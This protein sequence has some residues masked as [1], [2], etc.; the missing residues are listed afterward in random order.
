MLISFQKIDIATETMELAS[1]TT[2]PI[3]SLSSTISSTEPRY[4]FYR[5]THSYN[6]SS[7]SPI[8][9][10]YTCP[11]GS[12][13]RERM[14]YAA[15]SRSAIQVA[16]AEAGLKVEKKIEASSPDEISEESIDADL[17]PK[18]EIKKA[19]ERPKRPGRK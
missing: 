2:T 5:Y 15:S 19:F 11:S 18:V 13:I 6:G 3:S 16:E 4:S 12:K 17:H 9:F 8:L 1:S 10:I 7:S 14:L